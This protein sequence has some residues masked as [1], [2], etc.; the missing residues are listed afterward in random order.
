MKEN[1][2]KQFRKL[3]TEAAVLTGR[4]M[5]GEIWMDE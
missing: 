1:H 5:T 4:Q 2:I 3:T